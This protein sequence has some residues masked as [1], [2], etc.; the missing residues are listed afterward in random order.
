MMM[1][2][3]IFNNSNVKGLKYYL[4][5]TGVV[6]TIYIYSMVTGLRFLSFSESSH[7]VDKSNSR[8]YNHK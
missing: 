7:S 6:L 8:L 3:K 1:P 4:I 5:L 2:N